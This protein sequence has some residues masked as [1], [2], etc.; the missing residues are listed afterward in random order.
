MN[1]LLIWKFY[2]SWKVINYLLISTIT[3]FNFPYAKYFAPWEREGGSP[4]PPE[5][6]SFYFEIPTF[7]YFFINI[8]PSFLVST[9]LVWKVYRLGQ[10]EPTNWKFKRYSFLSTGLTLVISPLWI[11]TRLVTESFKPDNA[12]NFFSCFATLMQR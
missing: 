9:S 10:L 4:P 3:Y 12:A 6:I 11:F 1:K 7:I 2:F 8:F 5:Y